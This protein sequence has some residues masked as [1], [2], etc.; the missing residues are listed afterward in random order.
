MANNFTYKNASKESLK[1]IIDWYHRH[2]LTT[3]GRDITPELIVESPSLINIIYIL[4]DRLT[5]PK[6]KV[7]L[8]T[9][10]YNYYERIT[11]YLGRQV[12]ESRLH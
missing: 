9:P 12:V 1:A 4:I 7:L 10:V 3:K 11:K 8:L 5:L 2:H 6:D